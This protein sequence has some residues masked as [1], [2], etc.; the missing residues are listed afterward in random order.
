[1]NLTPLLA[2]WGSII[3]TI[4]LTWNVIRGLQDRRKLK[5]EAY[6]G[7]FLPGD[8][9]KKYFYVVMTNI[10][11]RPILVSRYGALLKKKKGEKGNPATLIIARNLPKML[12]EGEYHIEFTEDL[13][14]FSRNIKNIFAGD[15][16]GKNW[17][18][19]KKNFK[20]LLKDAN[21]ALKEFQK[22][23]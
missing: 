19:S 7:Y 13:S 21:E 3:S 5:V 16:T 11:R 1:M 6:I 18:I 2:L 23:N 4:A 14:L 9:Q 17:K 15:S 22:N 8:T 20:Q 12:K 10:G